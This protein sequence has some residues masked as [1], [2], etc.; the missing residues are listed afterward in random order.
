MDETPSPRRGL[1]FRHRHRP[2]LPSTTPSAAAAP[3]RA[4]SAPARP[5]ILKLEDGKPVLAIPPRRRKRAN[6]PNAWPARSSA[7]YHEQAGHPHPTCRS[8]AWT[9]Y[10]AGYRKSRIERIETMSILVDEK[11]RVMIQGITGREGMA[12]A[13]LMKDY[14]TNVVAGVTPGPG[15]PGRLRRPRLRLGERGL[16]EAGP[17]RR[18]RHF[19][20]RRPW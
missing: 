19:R 20:A 5:K 8:R 17:D 16:G 4:A 9:E 12:R 7:A 6:A 10:R 11:T 18:Q 3:P 1:C 13:Q 14:G 2:D 15:R